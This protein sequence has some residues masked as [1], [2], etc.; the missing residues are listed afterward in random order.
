M[1]FQEF[2]I[3]KTQIFNQIEELFEENAILKMLLEIEAKNNQ[4]VNKELGEAR[5]YCTSKDEE[6]FRAIFETSSLGILIS[7]LSDKSIIYA[8]K[9]A[10]N[11]LAVSKHN[12][13]NW[14]LSYFYSDTSE[15]EKLWQNF[16][17]NGYVDEYELKCKKADGSLFSAMIS[18]RQFNYQGKLALLSVINDRGKHQQAEVER[19]RFFNLSLDLFCDEAGSEYINR[20]LAG[21]DVSIKNKLTFKTGEIRSTKIR[22]VPEYDEDNQFK[23]YYCVITDIS[24][25][26]QPEDALSIEEENYRSI[27]ENALEGIFQSTPNGY[28]IK[29]NPAMAKIHGYD[30]PQEMMAKVQ[31]IEEQIYVDPNVWKKFKTLLQKQDKIENF[32]YQVYRQDG[33]IIWIEESTR[34]VRDRHGNLL[35]YQGTVQDITKRKQKEEALKCQIKKLCISIDQ[36]KREKEVKSIVESEYFQQLKADLK[37]LRSK[38]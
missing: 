37:E 14:K 28:Y 29:V 12:L 38:Y 35:Y 33:R 18:M 32:E 17:E 9:K 23:T 1:N 10:C 27:F 6:K 26:Q 11:T 5:P 2:L 31:K 20:V 16:Q 24:D 25:L 13:L 21:E 30:S 15:E 22:L 19:N 7:S 4:I 36:E 34:A 8:N 3:E